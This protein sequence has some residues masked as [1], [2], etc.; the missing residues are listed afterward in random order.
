MAFITEIT[1]DGELN[2]ALANFNTVCAANAALLALAP[3]DLTAI[4]A[5]ATGFNTTYNA[6]TAAK[7]A[8]KNSVEAKDIQKKTSK[9]AVSKYAKLFR[10]NLAVPDNLLDSLML[11]H[12]KTPGSKTPPTQ[13][14]DLV[15][16]A[17]GNGLV[18]LKWKRNGN[19]QGT[20]FLLEVRTDPAGPWS[21]SGST[22]QTKFGYQAVPGVYIA[23]RVTATRRNLLSPPSVPI[24]LWENGGGMSLRLAA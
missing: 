7:A 18:N 24:V 2:T 23:F 3:G 14:L 22:T 12:H 11:P 4:A 20:Q 21:I 10:A 8:A 16:S 19:T 6:A 5:A 17:D 9:T 13:P 15:G 1:A